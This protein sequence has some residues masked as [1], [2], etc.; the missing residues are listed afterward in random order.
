VRERERFGEERRGG[1]RGK[2]G[3]KAEKMEMVGDKDTE[4]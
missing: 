2:D 4:S 1:G 3:G